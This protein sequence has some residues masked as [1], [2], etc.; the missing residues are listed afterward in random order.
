MQTCSSC[1][2]QVDDSIHACTNCQADL[3]QYSTTAVALKAM[4]ANSRVRA[5][6]ISVD[7]DACPACQAAFGTFSKD[8]VVIDLPV[9]GCSHTGGCRCVYAPILDEIY[10]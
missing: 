8:E 6:R 9:E 10:P 7:A 4:R 1:H 5:V 2:T 3:Y